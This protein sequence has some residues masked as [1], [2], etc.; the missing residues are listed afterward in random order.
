MALR[1]WSTTNFLRYAAGVVTAVPVTLSAWG[2]TSITGG[3]GQ[4]LVCLQTSGSANN[5]NRFALAVQPTTDTIGARTSSGSAQSV[6]VTS[7]TIGA[8]TW[9]HA[10]G[11]FASAT[12][13]AAY[14]NGGGKGTETT[15]RVPSGIDRTSVGVGDGSSAAEPFAP[16]GTGDIAEVGIWDV[17][18]TDAEV[19]VLSRGVSPLFVRP[20]A[21]IAYF[22]IMGRTSP[23]I[24]YLD[25]TAVLSV[26]GTLTAAAHVPIK[27]PR[28]PK[29]GQVASAVVAAG[30]PTWKRAG[31][32]AFMGGS[33][34][35]QGARV[36]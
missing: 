30:Q 13:R 31:G 12:S 34:I 29:F 8:D 7:T 36:W 28:S 24:N 32:V 14:L 16:A 15:S 21:L 19:L 22:P 33:R 35:S 5:R 26:Q 3:A 10:C 27:M 23:E 1:D 20:A 25:R 4:V 18:L 9:F 11:V 17:A 6:A 2:K